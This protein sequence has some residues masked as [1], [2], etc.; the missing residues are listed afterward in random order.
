MEKT[1]EFVEDLLEVQSGLIAGH[2]IMLRQAADW[3]AMSALN[4]IFPSSEQVA[5]DWFERWTRKQE[6]EKEQ[7]K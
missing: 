1:E 4:M 6:L 2:K 5:R 3:A 7:P